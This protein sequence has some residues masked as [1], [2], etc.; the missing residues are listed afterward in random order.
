[1]NRRSSMLGRISA[2]AGHMKPGMYRAEFEAAEKVFSSRFVST[3]SGSL[4]TQ[5][6]AIVYSKHG[7]PEQVLSVKH[8]PLGPLGPNK[9]L[10]KILAASVNPADIN[11]IQG[12]Y[13][14][15]TS[16]VNGIDSVGGNEGV[17]QVIAAGENVHTV[18]P[19]DWVLP[20][21]RAIGSW[22]TYAIAECNDLLNL[23]QVEGVSHVSAATI[24][25]NPPTAYRMIKDFAQLQPGDVI[26]QNS[27]NSG[28]GQAVI[29]LAH[30]W[31][32]KTVNVVRN[33]P[34]LEVLIKQLKDLGA[35]MVVTEEQLRTPEIMRQ[36]AAL[37]PA[38]KL[39]LNGVGG[40]SA[41]NV[42]RLLGRHAHFVTYGGMSKEPVALPTSLFIF[43]DIKCFGFWLNEW[44]ELHPF[45]E[46]KQLFTELLDLVRQGKLKEP[47]HELFSLSTKTDA[48]LTSAIG[49]SLS[50]FLNGKLVLVP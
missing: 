27:A 11:V 33:R 19:G 1:M 39:G 41:T 46:R 9:V 16:F 44:F 45:S 14:V 4:P 30:A 8:I 18:S 24:S 23:G 42:A 20:I 5:S 26:I 49:A 25:V 48:E 13:P 17:G 2:L 36:I 28:V 43:K 22:Q 12:T 7:P 3:V 31:G 38:P 34:N 47:T 21:T 15:K 6:K 35:D 32:F 50:G 37:G 29:Q 10:V 40:K